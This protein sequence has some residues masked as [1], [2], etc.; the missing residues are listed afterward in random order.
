MAPLYTCGL[1]LYTLSPLHALA[2]IHVSHTLACLHDLALFHTMPLIAASHTTA[3]HA[4]KVSACGG[5]CMLGICTMQRLR[6]EC[7][8]RHR[9]VVVP[10]KTCESSVKPSQTYA[11]T[12]ARCC[13][14]RW[15]MVLR[16]AACLCSNPAA[17]IFQLVCDCA[18]NAAWLPTVGQLRSQ[19]LLTSHGRSALLNDS[20][21]P[22]VTL[23][24]PCSS[25][26][27]KGSTHKHDGVSC[28]L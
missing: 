23:T 10:E 22:P 7:C 24:C 28:S 14:R 8:S 15:P 1:A 3:S 19:L 11:P 25:P 12:A 13:P 26:A 4:L 27:N 5:S 9:P 16:E 6:T 2:L 17:K 18:V 20:A 21:G